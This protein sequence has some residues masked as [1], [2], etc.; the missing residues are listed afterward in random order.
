MS[1]LS[2]LLFI[3][4]AADTPPDSA[5]VVLTIKLIHLSQS[6]A[7]FPPSPF[8]HSPI[9]VS[10]SSAIQAPPC[11]ALL[12]E[13]LTLNLR[14]W[15]CSGQRGGHHE[16]DTTRPDQTSGNICAPPLSLPT[17]HLSFPQFQP[18]PQAPVTP[19]LPY[20]VCV[21]SDKWISDRISGWSGWGRADKW[22]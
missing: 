16:V 7:L 11:P 20:A 13:P 21:V 19:P 3:N 18:L 1:L 2:R 10:S 14:W 17:S 8:S 9:P 4:T 22:P 12:S 6:S 15:W 5:S